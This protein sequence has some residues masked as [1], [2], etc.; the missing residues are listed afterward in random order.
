MRKL[1]KHL[2]KQRRKPLVSDLSS[3]NNFGNPIA[4]PKVAKWFI[5]TDPYLSFEPILIMAHDEKEVLKHLT[6]DPDMN[7][8]YLSYIPEEEDES[9]I[10]KLEEELYV[11]HV[12]PID[13][14]GGANHR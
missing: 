12:E 7:E 13:L 6:K 3:I 10:A 4:E 8:R 5:V 11:T 14:I 1:L 2:R 9:R